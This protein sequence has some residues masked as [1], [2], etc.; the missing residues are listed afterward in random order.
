MNS[1]NITGR[2]TNDIELKTTQQGTSVCSFTVAVDRPAVKDKTDFIDC[3]AWRQKAE[4]LGKYFAK[5][6][7]IEITGVLTT[8]NYEDKSGN[9][10]KAV[11]VVCDQVSFPKGKKRSD[12]DN[13]Q[14]DNAPVYSGYD[15]ANFEEL[16]DDEDLPF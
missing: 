3:V 9:K 4:F 11:E 12:G 6:D 13:S 7:G 8:R 15:S 14:Q 5:G 10:R 2:V 1:I 16:G